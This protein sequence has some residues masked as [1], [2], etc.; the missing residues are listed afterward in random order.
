MLK[1]PAWLGR[2]LCSLGVHD[3]RVVSETFGFGTRGVEKAECRRCGVTV[4]RAV[5]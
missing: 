2:L 4:T 3:Y 5:R 1:L